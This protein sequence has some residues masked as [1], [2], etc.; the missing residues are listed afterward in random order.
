MQMRTLLIL[1]L[2]GCSSY[3]G[4][5]RSD[6]FYPQRDHYRVRRIDQDSGPGGLLTTAWLLDNYRVNH[7]VPGDPKVGEDYRSVIALDRDGDGRTDRRARVELYDLRFVHAVDGSVLWTRTLPTSS[8]AAARALDVIAHDYVDRVGGGSYFDVSLSG[9]VTETRLGTRIV[10]EGP[11]RVGGVDGWMVTF[12]V[13]ALEQRE[14][15]PLYA[16]N[17]VTMVFCRPE[18]A[19]WDPGGTPRPDEGWPMLVLFAL[20]SRSELHAAHTPELLE[21]LSR[22][23]MHRRHAAP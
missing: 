16:G 6:A 9:E 17:R 14:A 19:L 3:G 10:E 21:L 13:L 11:V 23:D 8:V 1:L 7:G 15:N 20:A 2:A 5:F 22:V 12:D 18:D 4:H